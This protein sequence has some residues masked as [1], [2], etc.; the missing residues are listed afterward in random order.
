MR[1]IVSSRNAPKIR[2]HSN[3][4][5]KQV[6]MKTGLQYSICGKTERV[7]NVFLTILTILIGVNENLGV[8]RHLRREGL[9]P[10]PDKSSPVGFSMHFKSP[11]RFWYYSTLFKLWLSHTILNHC[12][13]FFL[14]HF[15]VSVLYKNANARTSHCMQ[16]GGLGA[17]IW[18]KTELT[19][20]L[21]SKKNEKI[22]KSKNSKN[23]N[24]KK[25]I[26]K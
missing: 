19:K 13:L 23:K 17:G 3:S 11:S 14:F 9:T 26:K 6:Y 12:S 24:N 20:Y 4:V 2:M 5:L 22:I 15:C 10:I 18:N 16:K 1:P 25:L 8:E 21:K 7:S